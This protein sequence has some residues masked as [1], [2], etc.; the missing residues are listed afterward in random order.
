MLDPRTGDVRALVGGR[1]FTH[2][3]YDRV[4]SARRQPGSSVKPFVYA[5]A[6]Q[7]GLALNTRI[8]T[9]PV[10]N[11]GWTPDDLVPDSVTS[12][13][14][15]EAF[16]KSSNSAAVRVGQWV[17][18]DNVIEMA[19]AAGIETP[20]PAYPSIFLGAA[21][22]IPAD[23]VAAYAAFGNG[24]YR[25]KPRLVTRVEDNRGKVLWKA[26]NDAPQTIH[27]AT[28]F[29]TLSLM[30][31]VVDRGTASSIRRRGFWLPAAGKTGTTNDAKDVWFVGMTPDLVA[32]VWLGFDQPRT[33]L[34][35]ASGGLLAAPVWADAMKA[36]YEKRPQPAP[37]TPPASVTSASIDEESG[38]L[39][40]DR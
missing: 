21:E 16:A 4:F 23:F 8:E 13:G 33:I 2:S 25:I 10:A 36:V 3:S 15:R 34:P 38:L 12:L 9:T 37:W 14:V 17:G 28:A 11:A 27:E 5:A 35:N 18:V 39:A 24:G 29:L 19:R 7:N 26:A 40:T 32:G 30:E 22:V 20:I 1:D 6:I 31:D